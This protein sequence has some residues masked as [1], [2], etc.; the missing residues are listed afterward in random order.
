M[1][2]KSNEMIQVEFQLKK[3]A[4]FESQGKF[5]HSIQI[6]HS[7]I[8]ENPEHIPGYIKL[9][10]LYERMENLN[11][12]VGLLEHYLYHVTDNN[13]IRLFMGEIYLK[14]RMWNE[15]VSVMS[16]IALEEQ[17]LVSFFLAH[18]YFMLNEFESSRVHYVTFL[19]NND[20]T[21]YHFES[22]LFLAKCCIE[23]EKFS[24]A[25]S[26]INKAEKIYSNWETSWLMGIIYYYQSMYYHAVIAFEKAIKLNEKEI[27]LLEWAGKSYLKLGDYINAY[28]HLLKY[29]N[30]VGPSSAAYTDIAIACLNLQKTDEAVLY[31]DTAIMLD[32]KNQ[33]ALEGKKKMY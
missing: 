2:I 3:A 8:R 25:M 30:F 26:Y 4:E 7:I 6:Y 5:L 32:P 16:L 11:A 15:A 12:A 1:G 28:K 29:I 13:D 23:I 18:A 19:N 20:N 14:N 33:I 10:T 9:A 22:Y 24:E 31:F 27:S 17:P 21:E